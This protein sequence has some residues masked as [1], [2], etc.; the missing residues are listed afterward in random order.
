V[1]VAEITPALAAEAAALRAELTELVELRAMQQ[2]VATDLQAA[3]AALQDSRAE[4]S[5]AIDARGPLPRRE[6]EDPEVLAALATG[7]DAIGSLAGGL[8]PLP[9]P[10]AETAA[11][12]ARRGSLPLPAAARLLR[13]MNETDAAGIARPGLVLSTAPGALLRAPFAATVR[14]IGPL[15]RYG[16]VMVLEPAGDYLLVLS[17]FGTVYVSPGEVV[18]EGA[19]LA[20]MPGRTAPEAAG[21]IV[22]AARAGM[23]EAGDAT[24]YLELRERGVPLDPAQW[25]TWAER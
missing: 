24:L 23:A 8:V 13:G 14:F 5:R 1:V 6:V 11:F 9:D 21:Q 25:F 3:L 20:L 12:S 16:N 2:A 18:G 10:A 7:A 15:G 17:G 22:A 19:A 4:L